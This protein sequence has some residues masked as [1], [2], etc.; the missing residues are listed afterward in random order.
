MAALFGI[1]VASF[2]WYVGLR[3]FITALNLTM[4]GSATTGKVMSIARDSVARPTRSGSRPASAV[5]AAVQFEPV[6]GEPIT[7]TTISGGAYRV[8]QVVPVLYDPTNPRCAVV[9]C[10][11]N[12]W[13]G[14]GLV[15]TGGAVF[16]LLSLWGH[17][18]V[19]GAVMFL[20]LVAAARNARVTAGR[21]AAP[22]DR[23]PLDLRI[24]FWAF[25]ALIVG[26]VGVGMLLAML[27]LVFGTVSTYSTHAAL[28]RRA[29]R[30]DRAPGCLT[31]GSAGASAGCH[32]ESARIDGKY[33]AGGRPT[34]YY[35]LLRRATGQRSTVEALGPEGYDLWHD[36]GVGDRVVVQIWKGRLTMVWAGPYAMRTDQNPDYQYTKNTESLVLLPIF[37][38]MF[39]LSTVGAAVA[40]LR[41]PRSSPAVAR[42]SNTVAIRAPRRDQDVVSG[43]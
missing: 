14:P 39:A 19:I 43:E 27:L 3:G 20:C 33:S 28:A 4:R 5:H 37:T 10:V 32:T 22:Q 40:R 2:F 42:W 13:L 15:A 11:R 29:A 21:H 38:V 16:L 30:Y 24:W 1:L 34:H 25:K 26:I 7:F 17:P 18:L 35:L 8:G 41:R 36:A 6:A 31:P 12:L 23:L 9:N